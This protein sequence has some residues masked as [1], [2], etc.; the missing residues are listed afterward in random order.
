MRTGRDRSPC[1]PNEGGLS[2]RHN[3]HCALKL[4]GLPT[5]EVPEVM[6]LYETHIRSLSSDDIS[7]ATIDYQTMKYLALCVRGAAAQILSLLH[8][9]SLE[10]RPE[11]R[12]GALRA[13]DEQ[14]LIT[15][16]QKGPPTSS[17]TFL[18]IFP[19]VSWTVRGRHGLSTE[20]A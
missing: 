7:E 5:E 16:P 10:W 8:S 6:S 13:R 18:S 2:A 14:I 17:P 15:H 19:C 12:P 4:E 9:S 1:A 3:L 20:L 11:P